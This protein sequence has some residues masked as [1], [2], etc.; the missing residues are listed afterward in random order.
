[1]GS[2]EFAKE[3]IAKPSDLARLQNEM[4]ALP[5]NDPN[6]AAYE[7][8]IKK[9]SEF[10]PVQPPAPSIT[11]IVDPKD[12]TKLIRIDTKRYK[13]GSFGD[14]G[15]IGY[16]GK[17]PTAAAKE[18]KIEAGKTQLQT[19]ID[20]M[21]SYYTTLNEA[22]DIPSTERGGVSNVASW[23][24]GSTAGQLGGRMIGTE[25]QR[26][27]TNITNSKLALL[28]ALKQATG[29]SAQELNSNQE[30]KT[31]LDALS[32]VNQGYES[33]MD[34]LNNLEDIYI[35]GVGA[36]KQNIIPKNEKMPSNA[37]AAKKAK[38]EAFQKSQNKASA[39]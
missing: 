25:S 36:D 17:E 13:G 11:E 16:S 35:R 30:L 20:N 33:A 18:N 2:K 22:K 39:R 28:N 4:N 23:V 21:R 7:A 3:S 8:A 14:E 12:P 27:R 26:A 9:E 15:V 6:R 37:S 24:Q 1:M 34:T 19:M 10:A 32:D 5:P 38:F 31:N 29:K